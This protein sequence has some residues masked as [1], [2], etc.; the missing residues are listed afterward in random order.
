MRN[1]AAEGDSFFKKIDFIAPRDCNDKEAWIVNRGSGEF[2]GDVDMLTGARISIIANEPDLIYHL[3]A[4]RIRKLLNECTASAWDQRNAV[5]L[6]S[7]TDR[8]R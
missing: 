4:G 5:A 3:A 7:E 1:P 6:P 8:W 2:T